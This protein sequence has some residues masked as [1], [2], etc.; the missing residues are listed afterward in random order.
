MILK[1]ADGKEVWSRLNTAIKIEGLVD[2]NV[3]KFP[4]GS[5]FVQM[6]DADGKLTTK[7]IVIVR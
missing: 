5:Y 2:I 3:S 6:T 1:T 7:K 4:A